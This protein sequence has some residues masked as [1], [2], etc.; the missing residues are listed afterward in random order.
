MKSLYLSEWKSFLLNS[1]VYTD[2]QLSYEKKSIVEEETHQCLNQQKRPECK[3][4]WVRGCLHKQ[5]A[6]F[7][8]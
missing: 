2:V 4:L 3:Y 7:A 5:A 8:N 6:V 1:K